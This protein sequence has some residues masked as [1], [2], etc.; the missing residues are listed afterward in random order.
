V[1]AV[2]FK[3]SIM[4]RC[5]NFKM[6][7]DFQKYFFKISHDKETKHISELQKKIST[8]SIIAPVQFPEPQY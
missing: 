6:L 7:H 3:L 2:N 5:K 8:K 1:F 4:I